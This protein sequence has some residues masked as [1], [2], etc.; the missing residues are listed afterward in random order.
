MSDS[1]HE[2]VQRNKGER[3]GIKI[4]IKCIKQTKN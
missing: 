2:K 4:K 3:G 1:K